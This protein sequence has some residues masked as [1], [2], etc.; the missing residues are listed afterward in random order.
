MSPVC[1]YC[2]QDSELVSGDII[3]PHRKD[4]H[5]KWFYLCKPCDAYVGCHPDTQQPLGRLA[6][7]ELRKYKSCAHAAFD[8]YWRSGKVS[9]SQAYQALAARLGILVKNC[10][11]GM[12]DVHTCK[13]VIAICLNNK[14]LEK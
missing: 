1:N 7:A 8:P 5:S 14:L 11:I 3:Y 2:K 13:R 6:N 10:H 12:F 9:R 4:L